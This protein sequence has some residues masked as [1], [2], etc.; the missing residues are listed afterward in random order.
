MR[1]R[2]GQEVPPQE[3][4]GEESTALSMNMKGEEEG[5]EEITA[6]MKEIV[7]D[8]PAMIDEKTAQGP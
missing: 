5:Q 1:G 6:L 3:D 8:T 7:G 2:R 4:I